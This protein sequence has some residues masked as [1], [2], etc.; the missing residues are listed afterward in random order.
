MKR[1][2]KQR[3]DE[4]LNSG[5]SSSDI[6]AAV[7]KESGM[8]EVEFT[9]DKDALIEK[10]NIEDRPMTGV[11][12]SLEEIAEAKR[13]QTRQSTNQV[14]PQHGDSNQSSRGDDGPEI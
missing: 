3:R 6:L 13:A 10:L 12:K 11:T 14:A 5:K 8:P 7:A 4:L 1:I 2:S 9:I